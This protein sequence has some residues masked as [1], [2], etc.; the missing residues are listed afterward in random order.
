MIYWQLPEKNW[1]WLLFVTM[2][3]MGWLGHQ[4]LT[5]AHRYAPAAVLAPFIY[6]Q[7]VYMTASSWL[8]FDQPPSI[9]I[10]VGAPIVVAS[11]IYIWWRERHLKGD[12]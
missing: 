2:G 4:M 3:C 6:V 7:L 11:G 12:V 1:H 9:W 5:A 10:A 8:I